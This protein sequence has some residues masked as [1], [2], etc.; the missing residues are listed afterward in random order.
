MYG[1]RAQ[2]CSGELP[3]N[4]AGCRP[5]VRQGTPRESPRATEMKQAASRLPLRQQDR[6][7]I[8]SCP[9]RRVRLD[10]GDLLDIETVNDSQIRLPTRP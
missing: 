9:D 2:P 6:D 5:T 4:G 10:A 7:R 3:E 8:R 1:N